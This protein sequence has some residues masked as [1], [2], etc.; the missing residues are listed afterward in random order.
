M[1]NVVH[2]MTEVYWFNIWLDFFRYL[3]DFRYLLL[4]HIQE[5]FYHLTGG[6]LESHCTVDIGKA[7]HKLE[8]KVVG[9]FCP[10]KFAFQSKT[11]GL[12]KYCIY[13]I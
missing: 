2:N 7:I 3:R 6:Q 1:G 9:T 4:G 11:K 8:S 5:G 12:L 13:K 10:H